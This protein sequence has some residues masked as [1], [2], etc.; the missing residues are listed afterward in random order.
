M[1]EGAEVL[2]RVFLRIPAILLQDVLEIEFGVCE[3]L[4]WLKFQQWSVRLLK[5]CAV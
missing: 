5:I 4:G 3:N 2:Q 1:G